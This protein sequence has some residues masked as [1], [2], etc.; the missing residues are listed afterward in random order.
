MG[1]P[2]YLRLEEAAKKYGISTEMLLRAAENGLVRAVRL[3]RSIAI[4]EA[5]VRRLEER[6]GHSRLEFPRYLSL[7]EAAERYGISEE[8]LKR[9]IESGRMRA[10]YLDEEVAVAEVD[11]RELASQERVVIRLEDFESLRGQPISI[12]EAAR[13]YGLHT[14]TISRWAQRGYIRRLGKQGKKVLLDKAD[15]AYCVAVYRSLGGRAGAWIFDSEGNPYHLKNPE[16]ARG[17]RPLV[18]VQ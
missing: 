12:S 4:A 10:I 18:I 13:E 14:S 8:A 17:E 16:R 11:V 7:A 6:N 15:V 2:R 3:N 9:A 5:D 1:A